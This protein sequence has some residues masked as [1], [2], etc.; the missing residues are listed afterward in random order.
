MVP[1]GAAAPSASDLAPVGVPAPT[2]E[3]T[4]AAIAVDRI[5][6]SWLA[7]RAPATATEYERDYAA[8]LAWWTAERGRLP[9]ELFRLGPED[10]QAYGTRLRERLGPSAVCRALAVASSLWT[11]AG[12]QA[13]A[14]GI[15][16][17]NPWRSETVARPPVRQRLTERLLTE[18]DVAKLI[19]AGRDARERALLLLTYHCGLRI[20]EAVTVQWRD[21]RQGMHGWTVTILGKGGKER[22][23]GLSDR[24][25]AALMALRPPDA[26][27]TAFVFPGGEMGH[28]DRR[29]VWKRLKTLARK[30]GVTER[31]SAHWLR[32]SAASHALWHGADLATVQHALGHSSVAITAKYVHADPSR[33]LADYLPGAGRTRGGQSQ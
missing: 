6:R 1:Q 16:V 13:A 30:A 11:Y 15:Y 2:R 3:D 21:I 27:D 20:S 14:T 23:C 7:S 29:N 22:T 17:R 24:A 33:S 18:E 8:L 25:A 32:H 4:A 28:V 9:G 10:A 19:R 5:T 31:V 12:R 26:P